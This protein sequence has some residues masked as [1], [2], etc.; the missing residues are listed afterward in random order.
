MKT[1]KSSII[2]VVLFTLITAAAQTLMK[3]GAKNN[4]VNLYTFFGLSLYGAGTIMFI[5]ALKNGELSILYPIVSLSFAWVSL[6]AF[7]Y[8]KE[9]QSAMNIFG[10]CVILTGVSLLGVKSL[11]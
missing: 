11:K 5:L 3:I 7:F 10:V 2:L 4:F 9:A 8:L 1:K 6:I